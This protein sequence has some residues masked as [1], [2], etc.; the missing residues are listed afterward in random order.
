M[1]LPIRRIGTHRGRSLATV[2]G[3]VAVCALAGGCCR[4][5]R[6]SPEE[7]RTEMATQEAFSPEFETNRVELLESLD[8]IRIRDGVEGYKVVPTEEAKEAHKGS[9]TAFVDPNTGKVAWRALGCF[10][11]RCPGRPNGGIVIVARPV[12]NIGVGQGG[13]LHMGPA[14]PED[15]NKP[16]PCP[17]CGSESYWQAYDPPETIRRRQEL[18]R[19]LN[20]TYAAYNAASK[21]KQP[22]PRDVRPPNKILEEIDNL[23]KI[24]L[25]PE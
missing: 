3:V 5:S 1:T 24:F 2:L 7:L 13:A 15:L 9:P 4:A 19:E 12:S 23:P 25:V 14:N 20:A 8:E 21:R 11:P 6:K 10:N 17:V 22:M 18:Q 16:F